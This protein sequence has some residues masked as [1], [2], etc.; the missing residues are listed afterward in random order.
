ME[1]TSESYLFAPF[2][3]VYRSPILQ[4]KGNSTVLLERRSKTSIHSKSNRITDPIKYKFKNVVTDEQA[5]LRHLLGTGKELDMNYVESN[6]VVIVGGR[7]TLKK[8]LH[9]G[10]LAYLLQV[11]ANQVVRHRSDM[12]VTI[13]HKE[14]GKNNMVEAEIEVKPGN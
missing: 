10:L 4:I 13:E 14:S 9:L 5:M 7:D 8:K 1:H 6:K 3:K 12:F 2:N 11:A